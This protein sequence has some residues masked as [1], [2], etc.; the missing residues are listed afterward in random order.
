MTYRKPNQFFRCKSS[1]KLVILEFIF[2]YVLNL[3]KRLEIMDYNTLISFK[4]NIRKST[5]SIHKLK[6]EITYQIKFFEILHNLEILVE[7][8]VWY[9]KIIDL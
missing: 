5:Y 3:H 1:G 8:N 4:E 7:L 2:N 6:D 9:K